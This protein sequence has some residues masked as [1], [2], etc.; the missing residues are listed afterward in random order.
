MLQIGLNPQKISFVELSHVF[1]SMTTFQ[2]PEVGDVSTTD[3]Q[4][5]NHSPGSFT[6]SIVVPLA[7]LAYLVALQGFW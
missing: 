5:M 4:E 7:A 3:E 1:S 2:H 6:S